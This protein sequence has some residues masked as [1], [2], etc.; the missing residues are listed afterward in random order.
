MAVAALGLTLPADLASARTE[1]EYAQ[2]RIVGGT[3]ADQ[4]YPWMV[5]LQKNSH[6]CGGS[7]VSPEWIVTAARCLR[8]DN[9]V[10]L[11]LRIGSVRKDTGGVLV[12]PER[13]ETH[14]VAD[15]AVIQLAAPVD[16]QPVP[17]ADS[18]AEQ[19]P[20]RILG[21]GCTRDPQDHEG[22]AEP[23]VLQQLDTVVRPADDCAD[24]VSWSNLC[25]GNPEANQGAC[26]FDSGGPAVRGTTGS[27]A[28]VGATHG[29]PACGTAPATYTDVTYYRPWIEQWIGDA[30]AETS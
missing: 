27:S 6:F 19:T 9:F 20:V 18:A 4:T 15:L 5:S 7:L 25:V 21:W 22:C 2:R 14:P 16:L 12:T 30:A 29:G 28:L 10:G 1:T 3:D 23:E 8:A 13:F 17:I 26:L 24:R 11:Q